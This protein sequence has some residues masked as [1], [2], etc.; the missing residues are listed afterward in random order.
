[1]RV[2]LIDDNKDITDMVAFY[3]QA[4]DVSCKVVNDG[5]EG[6]ETIRNESFDAIILDLAMPDFSGFDIFTALKK[7]DLLRSVNIVIFT[8]SSVPDHVVQDMMSSGAKGIL[9]KPL[10][11]DDLKEMIENYR[12]R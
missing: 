6:L 12:P 4:Q 8:A 3:L 9:K 5:K 7:D 2:L 11:L 10:S 1:M